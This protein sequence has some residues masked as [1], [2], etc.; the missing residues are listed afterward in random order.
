[1]VRNTPP[2]LDLP[3]NSVGEGWSLEPLGGDGEGGLESSWMDQSEEKDEKGLLSA[4]HTEQESQSVQDLFRRFIF[5]YSWRRLTF[6]AHQA[7]WRRQDKTEKCTCRCLFSH[8]E[9]G[10]MDV[11]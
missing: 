5:L 7:H 6:H 1:M 3:L 10:I 8:R 9:V 11:T 2:K 4:F